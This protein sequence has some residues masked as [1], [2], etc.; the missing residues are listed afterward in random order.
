MQI[1]A[2]FGYSF[3]DTI[4]EAVEKAASGAVIMAGGSDLMP[5]LKL[6]LLEP[7]E[8]VDISRIPGLSGI[9][10]TETGIRIGSMTTL[11]AIARDMTILEK[12]PVL[13]QAA[14]NVASP[15]IRNRGTIGGNVLQSRR[16]FY[17]NQSHEWR[18]GIPVCRKLGGEVCLQM[19]KS[20]VCRAIYYSDMAPALLACDATAEVYTRKGMCEMSVRELVHLHCTDKLE[21]MVVMAFHIPANAYAG[22]AALFRK[23]SLRGSVD[24]PI[25]NFAAAVKADGSASIMVGAI[26][27]EVVSLSAAAEYIAGKGTD[28][29]LEEAFCMAVKEMED[30]SQLIREAG[31][32]IQVKRSAFLQ[33]RGVLEAVRQ[34]MQH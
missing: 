19:Q 5:R 26:A 13:S 27:P 22:P 23:Y 6:D 17:Y 15:Q 1:K 20:P 3:P 2:E 16:C 12:A 32:S 31:I 11:D 25:I 8:M 10:V 34:K 24:F 28:F 14:R 7:D 30:K 9:T 29:D 33:V 4:Q 18:Q 21:P